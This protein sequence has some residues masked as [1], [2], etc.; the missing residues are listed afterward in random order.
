[1]ETL[2]KELK[3][4]HLKRLPMNKL[5]RAIKTL[6]QPQRTAYE[7]ICE[8]KRIRAEKGLKLT[9]RVL[10]KLGLIKHCPDSDSKN[11]Y[12]LAGE[13]VQLPPKKL[14]STKSIVDAI[15]DDPEDEQPKHIPMAIKPFVR[16]RAKY[17]NPSREDHVR[18]WIMQAVTSDEKTIVKVKCLQEWQM[19]FVMYNYEN[20]TAQQMADRLKVGV[21]NV[22]IFC[23]ANAIDLMPDLTKRKAKDSFHAIPE[24]RRLRMK[25]G[26]Y[27]GPQKKTA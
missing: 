19:K 8:T 6:T 4:V 20:Q 22:K 1:M 2:P 11:D 16:P 18:K 15:Q 3:T 7:R 27:N 24:S 9:C 14:P 17:D 23:Q 10:F 21:M 25:R 12:V 13:P 5:Q 26:D